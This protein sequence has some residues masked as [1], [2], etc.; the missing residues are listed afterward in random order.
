MVISISCELFSVIACGLVISGAPDGYLITT[1]VAQLWANI[2]SRYQ[3]GV[4]GELLDDL[5]QL[6]GCAPVVA[7][8]KLERA[9]F[10]IFLFR[11]VK[12]AVSCVVGLVE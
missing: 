12:V 11:L 10:C 8:R 7:L 1:L 3:W 2:W 5:F 4:G 6:P 9:C